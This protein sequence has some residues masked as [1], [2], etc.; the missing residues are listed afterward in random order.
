MLACLALG[1][2][3]SQSAGRALPRTTAGPA[4]GEGCYRKDSRAGGMGGY[5][6]G[7]S[8]HDGYRNRSDGRRYPAHYDGPHGELLASTHA[9]RG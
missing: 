9:V 8:E 2:Y 4:D 3:L 7:G 1:S 5:G 6:Y